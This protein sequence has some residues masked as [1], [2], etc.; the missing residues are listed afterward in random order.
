MPWQFYAIMDA[1]LWFAGTI[2]GEGRWTPQLTDAYAM[3]SREC[4]LRWAAR[5]NIHPDDLAIVAVDVDNS[6]GPTRIV[7]MTDLGTQEA[8]V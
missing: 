8:E 5:L 2:G 4:A 7:G 1:G 6:K 3:P